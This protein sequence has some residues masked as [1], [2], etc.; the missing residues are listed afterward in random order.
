MHRSLNSLLNYIE[1]V[2][3]PFGLFDQYF[4]FIL[5]LF[6]STGLVFQI[7]IIQILLGLLNIVLATKILTATK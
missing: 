7:L 3:E 4:E 6:Y 2:I 1:E 5:V